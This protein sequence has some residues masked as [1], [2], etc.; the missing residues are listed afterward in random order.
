MYSNLIIYQYLIANIYY[1]FTNQVYIFQAYCK[2][3]FCFTC[4][5]FI[6]KTQW[7]KPKFS[8]FGNTIANNK[9]GFGFQR[10]KCQGIS[11]FSAR[12][13]KIKMTKISNLMSCHS[14]KYKKGK[15][16][17]QKFYLSTQ[18][19]SCYLPLYSIHIPFNFIALT[20][21][22]PFLLP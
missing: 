15:N 20:R 1:I 16:F 8:N 12:R 7:L 2:Y 4:R 22:K 13:I 18:F 5:R 6:L 11:I 9:Q 17:K 21:N 19:I 3:T 10:M 14:L